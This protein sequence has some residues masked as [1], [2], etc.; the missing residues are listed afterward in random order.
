MLTDDFLLDDFHLSGDN[1]SDFRTLVGEIDACTKVYTIPMRSLTVFSLLDVKEKKGLPEQFKAWELAPGN[2][3]SSEEGDGKIPQKTFEVRDIFQESGEKNEIPP[4]LLKEFLTKNKL[5]FAHNA[6]ETA[7]NTET[8]GHTETAGRFYISKWALPTLAQ[9]IGVNKGA[10]EKRKFVNDAK[11]ADEFDND[12]RMTVVVKDR[13]KI[14]K[15]FA[16]MGERYVHIKLDD[17]CSVYDELA[18]ENMWT[19]MDKKRPNLGEMICRGWDITHEKVRISFALENYADYLYD[20]YQMKDRLVPCLELVDS[21]IGKSAF[22]AKGYWKTGSG[23]RIDGAIFK[24]KHCESAADGD[25]LRRRVREKILKQYE[26]FPSRL[27][28][29]QAIQIS[30]E[31][32]DLSK[33]K[34]ADKNKAAVEAAIASVLEQVGLFKVDVSKKKIKTCIKELVYDRIDGTRSYTAYDVMM[35]VAGMQT[36]WLSCVKKRESCS[37]T[38]VEKKELCSETIRKLR[39]ALAQAA[40]ADYSRLKS[41]EEERR[42]P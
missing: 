18:G 42:L 2:P 4:K 38:T 11:I 26:D 25:R 15:V 5:L 41:G 32:V 39:D 22:I 21:E 1:E 20:K 9:R 8:A 29:L 33:K 14:R 37:E 6:A 40:W 23:V 27:C 34:G 28:K 12:K 17:F 7:G 10:I 36:E 13:N 35:E 3:W 19:E 30:P 24:M 31:G 16:F